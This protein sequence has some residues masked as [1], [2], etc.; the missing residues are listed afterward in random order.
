MMERKSGWEEAR[1]RRDASV[2]RDSKMPLAVGGGEGSETQR[3]R[4]KGREK[5]YRF[6]TPRRI[7]Q[8]SWVRNAGEDGRSGVPGDGRE[9]VVYV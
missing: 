6:A 1:G 4:E 7:R 2:W 5:E 9:R 8:E 3:N